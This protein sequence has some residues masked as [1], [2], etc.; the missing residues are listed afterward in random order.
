MDYQIEIAPAAQRQIKKLPQ[1]IQERIL[2]RLEGLVIDPRSEGVVKLSGAEDLYRIR[3]GDYRIIYA[4][5][6]Q[7]LLVL[8]VKVGHRRDV[9]R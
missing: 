9:Y 7:A 3:V 5:E 8:I 2:Q 4:I 6:D 1:P